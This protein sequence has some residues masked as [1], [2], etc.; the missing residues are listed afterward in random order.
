MKIPKTMKRLCPHCKK[1]NE[2]K[3][4]N[5]KN[6]GLNKTHTQTK[7]S[8]TRT[9]KRGRRTGVGNQG[10]FSRPA[11]GKWKKTGAKSSKK[12][13]LRYTCSG[14]KKTHIQNQGIRSKRIEMK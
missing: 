10:R 3:V 6:R 9:K 2:H 5:Q 8:K 4:I 7:G 14:C 1:H 12:T 11:I 13:D